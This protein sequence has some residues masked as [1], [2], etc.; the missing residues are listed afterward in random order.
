MV[1]SDRGWAGSVA[2]TGGDSTGI[3]QTDIGRPL[4][5]A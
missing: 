5:A 3:S 2:A 1:L 4:V